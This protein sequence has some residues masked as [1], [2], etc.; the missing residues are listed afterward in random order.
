MEKMQ[1]GKIN[2]LLKALYIPPSV[3]LSAEQKKM[4]FTLTYTAVILTTL[5]YF[6]KPGFFSLLFPFAS[7][8]HHGLYPQLWWA[9]CTI[10]L[11]LVLP[12]VIIKLLLKENLSDYGWKLKVKAAHLSIYFLML[13]AVLPFVW[14][15]SQRGDFQMIYPFY[16]GAYRASFQE[17]F[18]WEA[19]YMIQFVALEFFFRGYLVLGMERSLGRLAIWIAVIPYCMIH[20]HKPPLE[21]FAAIVAGIILG[22]LSQR[23]RTIIGGAMIHMAVAFTMDM[24]ALGRFR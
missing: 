1:K 17:I 22:E 6:G 4:V 11:F 9:F 23:T 18:I 13:A 16:R 10:I 14:F 5:E 24:L 8:M 15:A 2:N 3:P 7:R 21:A 12:M 19:F 20:Y